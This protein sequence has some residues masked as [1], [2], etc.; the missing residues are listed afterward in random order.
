MSQT[1]EFKVFVGNVP[2]QC[3]NEEF[4]RT[5]EGVEGYVSSQVVKRHNSDASKGFG[6][7][8]LSSEQAM[9]SLINSSEKYVIDDRELRFSPYNEDNHQ[10]QG[11]SQERFRRRYQIFVPNLPSDMTED[12]LKSEFSQFGTVLNSS[13]R[14]NSNSG[15]TT[16]SISYGTIEEYQ[17]AL[18]DS[19]RSVAP[20]KK[21]QVIRRVVQNQQ[22]QQVRSG[23]GGI[24]GNSPKATYANGYTAGQR[25]GYQRGFQ[26]GYQNALQHF[27]ASAQIVQNQ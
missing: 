8:V 20:F 13:V 22:V 24:L 4:Q 27:P 15:Q 11:Q 6:F 9:N 19:Q 5:F 2:F 3:S 18:K 21:K 1:S 12:V 25:F 7:V 26:E 23:N 16:G 14:T 10:S 17:S